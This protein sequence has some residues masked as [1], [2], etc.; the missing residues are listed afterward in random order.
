MNTTAIPSNHPLRVA[1]RDAEPDQ[2]HDA[3]RARVDEK[4][5]ARTRGAGLCIQHDRASHR[6]LE[7]DA[8]SDAELGVEEV[9]A[10]GKDNVADGCV[11]ECTLQFGGI[12]H[13]GLQLTAV[14]GMAT[15]KVAEV[16]LS[17]RALRKMGK[18]TTVFAHVSVTHTDSTGYTLG[19]RHERAIRQKLTCP[20]FTG[21]KNLQKD[22]G[23]P[24]KSFLCVRLPP[25]KTVKGRFA[26]RRI[27]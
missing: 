8:P 3:R 13:R 10:G 7:D 17:A 21:K 11:G 19:F 25:V 6:R 1:S 2:L 14:L 26:A 12:A 22:S 18:Q 15:S 4:H 5:T 20:S 24:V 16:A 9:R 27:M 23:G